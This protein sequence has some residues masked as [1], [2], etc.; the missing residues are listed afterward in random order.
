MKPKEY[1]EKVKTKLK[2]KASKAVVGTAIAASVLF[3]GKRLFSDGGANKIPFNEQKDFAAAVVKG[4]EVNKFKIPASTFKLDSVSAVEEIS[5]LMAPG[6][7]DRKD[8]SEVAA[9]IYSNIK[10]I[11][12][13]ANDEGKPS[14]EGR[15]VSGTS[16]DGRH[17]HGY[18]KP[19]YGKVTP[20]VNTIVSGENNT[21]DVSTE[22]P[23]GYTGPMGEFLRAD[24]IS[25]FF[26]NNNRQVFPER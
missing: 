4:D 10:A 23:Y 6:F 11:E 13:A 1:L 25:V 16:L 18:L 21:Y 22:T 5:D 12:N 2:D 7:V 20:D 15:M 17:Q 26:A 8:K 9:T 24:R 19:S 14:I 3:G